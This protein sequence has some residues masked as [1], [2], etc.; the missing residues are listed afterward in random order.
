MSMTP[1]T[2]FI[3]EHLV[4]LN[5]TKKLELDITNLQK[6]TNDHGRMAHA[7]Y[8][9]ADRQSELAD[10]TRDRSKAEMHSNKAAVHRHIGDLHR[11]LMSAHRALASDWDSTKRYVRN[12]VYPRSDGMRHTETEWRTTHSALNKE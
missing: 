1:F 3:K 12:E 7:H 4:S 9:E 5:E 8:N 11:Q 2:Q 10:K 6:T